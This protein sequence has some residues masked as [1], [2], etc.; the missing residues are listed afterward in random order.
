MGQ[1][2]KAPGTYIG[3]ATQQ[4]TSNPSSERLMWAVRTHWDQAIGRDEILRVVAVL[5]TW[6]WLTPEN[7]SQE[8]WI[9]AHA[10]ELPVEV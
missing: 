9:Q 7:W 2:S 5:Q 4:P 10:F 6:I 8:R 3:T 1:S